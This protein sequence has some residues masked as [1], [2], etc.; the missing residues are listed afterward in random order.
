MKLKVSRLG[1]AATSESATHEV[2]VSQTSIT[3]YVAMEQ[4]MLFTDYRVS[5]S[6]RVERIYGFHHDKMTRIMPT[7]L[8]INTSRAPGMSDLEELHKGQA[9][10]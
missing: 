9:G 2:R 3:A 7:R 8:S 1:I 4:D 6:G 10:R 5:L